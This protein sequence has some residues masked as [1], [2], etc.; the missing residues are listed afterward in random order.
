MAIWRGRKKLVREEEWDTYRCRKREGSHTDRE[1]E[2]RKGE[3][4][5]W[6]INEI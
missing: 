5:K 3:N 1:K 2:R 4:D 6:T